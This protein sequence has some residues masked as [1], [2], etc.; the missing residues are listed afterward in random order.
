[1]MRN[2][3]HEFLLTMRNIAHIIIIGGGA[4]ATRYREMWK[5]LNRAGWRRVKGK[6]HDHA[7]DPDNP[8][9][10]IPVPHKHRTDIP[11]PTANKILKLAGLL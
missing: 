9:H 6:K 2:I 5:K 7:V 4:M 8:N 11:E 1:M 3:A 10:K